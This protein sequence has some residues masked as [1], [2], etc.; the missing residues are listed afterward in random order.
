VN[1]LF[2]NAKREGRDQAESLGLTAI[3]HHQK[4]TE[5]EPRGVVFKHDLIGGTV[6]GSG[7]RRNFLMIQRG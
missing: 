4:N 2:E 1:E 5:D 6:R 7:A 3:E